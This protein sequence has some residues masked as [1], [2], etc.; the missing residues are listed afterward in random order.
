[1]AKTIAEFFLRRWVEENLP[2]VR[3]K[4]EGRCAHLKDQNGDTMSIM[5]DPDTHGIICMDRNLDNLEYI[6]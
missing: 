6:P 1:M 5:Y 3:I 4:M 2:G